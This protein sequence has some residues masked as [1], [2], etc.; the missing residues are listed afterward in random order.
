MAKSKTKQKDADHNDDT[1]RSFKRVM[2]YRSRM[3]NPRNQPGKEKS[4]KQDL[5][6]IKPGESL[7]EFSRRI[8]D[9]IAVPK[10]RG[11]SSKSAEKVAKRQRLKANNLRAEYQQKWDAKRNKLEETEAGTDMWMPEK[12]DEDP[13]AALNSRK[14]QVKFGDVA[15]RPPELPRLKANKGVPRSAGSLARRELLEEERRRV[16]SKYREMKE[17]K[18]STKSID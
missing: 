18:S 9:T 6:K 16:I 4:L 14:E 12:D 8:N 15:D 1:P 13:W 7:K 11:V 3:A 17:K 10:S 5:P 2:D